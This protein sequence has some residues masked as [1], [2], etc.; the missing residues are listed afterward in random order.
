MLIFSIFNII[1][2]FFNIIITMNPLISNILLERT[3]ELKMPI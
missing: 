2:I 3:D 1:Y